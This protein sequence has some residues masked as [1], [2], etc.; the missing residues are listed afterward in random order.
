VNEP[1]ITFPSAWQ[2][3]LTW[4]YNFRITF[5]SKEIYPADDVSGAFRHLKY[6]PNVVAMHSH[7]ILDYFAAAT[8]TTFGDC[9]SPSNCDVVAQARRRSTR[10]VS[11][12][13]PDTISL[14]TSYLPKFSLA[15]PPTNDEQPNFCTGRGR[16][17]NHRS[18][19][20][21]WP[22]NTAIV[23][24]PRRRQHVR[25][26][27][28]SQ[29]ASWLFSRCSVSP[30][31]TRLVCSTTRNLMIGSV[32]SAKLLDARLIHDDGS[33]HHSCQTPRSY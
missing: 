25:R 12:H 27:R 7:C 8:G 6:H 11:G 21:G 13:Q 14:V 31:Q 22:K 15:P 29:Q 18:S 19:G 9:S 1:P 10:T 28:G 2:E 23:F 17:H 32:I 26:R 5:P 20:F 3:Y 16:L 4:P 33:Q 24:A 30:A